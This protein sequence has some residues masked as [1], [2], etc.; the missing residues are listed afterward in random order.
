[1]SLISKGNAKQFHKVHKKMDGKTKVFK[2][3][4]KKLQKTTN[5]LEFYK[6]EIISRLGINAEKSASSR[7]NLQAATFLPSLP[8]LTAYLRNSENGA[9]LNGFVICAANQRPEAAAC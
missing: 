8:K 2:G 9:I 3:F 7:V 1:M 4:S 5:E 6:F